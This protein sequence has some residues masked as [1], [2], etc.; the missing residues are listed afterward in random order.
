MRKARKVLGRQHF[1]IS[2]ETYQQ[3][4]YW[5]LNPTFPYTG[6]CDLVESALSTEHFF[7]YNL[8]EQTKG[9]NTYS[10]RVLNTGVTDNPREVGQTVPVLHYMPV[11]CMCLPP[12][13]GKCQ[14]G[15]LSNVRDGWE[16]SVSTWLLLWDTGRFAALDGPEKYCGVTHIP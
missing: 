6:K 8:Q 9:S 1:V 14:D 3:K 13:S 12:M 10:G 5:H 2:L 15:C 16:A 7:Q 11:T 4:L